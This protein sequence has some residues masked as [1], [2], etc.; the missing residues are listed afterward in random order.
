MI[1]NIEKEEVI[2]EETTGIVIMIGI[3]IGDYI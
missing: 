1:V 3:T 2:G